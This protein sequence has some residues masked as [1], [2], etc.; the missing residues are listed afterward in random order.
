LASITFAQDE[1]C[2]DIDFSLG[3]WVEMDKW[4]ARMAVQTEVKGGLV[5]ILA[6]WPEDEPIRE[7]CLPE[8][9]K[10]GGE[11]RIETARDDD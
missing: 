4:L 2:P 10:A 5:V 11:L 3:P 9:R 7:R 1:W 6:R 8:F